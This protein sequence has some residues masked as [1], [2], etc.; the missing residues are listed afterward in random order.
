MIFLNKK[1]FLINNAKIPSFVHYQTTVFLTKKF[2]EKNFDQK[3]FLIKNNDLFLKL[4]SLI[5]ILFLKLYGH[6]HQKYV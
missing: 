1:G 5:V 4:E 6:F 3:R 2:E